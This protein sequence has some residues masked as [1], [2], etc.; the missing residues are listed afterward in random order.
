M[1]LRLTSFIFCGLA[2]TNA[3]VVPVTNTVVKCNKG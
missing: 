3:V 1:M 2:L